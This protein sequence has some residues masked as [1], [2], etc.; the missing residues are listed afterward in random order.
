VLAGLARRDFCYE[1]RRSMMVM[2][3]AGRAK[4][5]ALSG[6][7]SEFLIHAGNAVGA[8]S[9][10]SKGAMTIDSVNPMDEDSPLLPP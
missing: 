9:A 7:R 4:R 6:P 8:P 1:R 5:A 10:S 2:N 3:V